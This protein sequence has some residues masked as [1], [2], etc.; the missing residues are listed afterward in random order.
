MGREIRGNAGLHHGNLAPI[1]ATPRRMERERDI[2]SG[3]K[4]IFKMNDEKFKLRII[5]VVALLIKFRKMTD[6]SDKRILRDYIRAV[7]KE[8]TLV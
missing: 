3:G 1:P 5:E 2:Y 6:K 4:K 8:L 7:V